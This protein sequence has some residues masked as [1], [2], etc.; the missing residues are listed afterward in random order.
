MKIRIIT[1]VL[2][3]ACV[4]TARAATDEP[5]QPIQ[6]VKEINLAKADLGKATLLRRTLI[7]VRHPLVRYLPQ[8]GPGRCRQPA[9]FGR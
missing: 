1:A 7:A 3:V 2:L 4:S 9:I 5:I 8:S 6:L